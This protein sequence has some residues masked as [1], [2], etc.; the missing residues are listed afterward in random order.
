MCRILATVNHCAPR[1]ENN[2]H[3]CFI[4]YHYKC[5]G[6]VCVKLF[7]LTLN[8]SINPDPERQLL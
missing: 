2:T 5:L 6:L 1:L 3:D 8:R 7:F 4:D